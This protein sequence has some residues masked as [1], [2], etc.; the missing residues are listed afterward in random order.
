MES[1]ELISVIMPCFNDAQCVEESVQSVLHQTYEAIEL[2]VVDDGSTDR[3]PEILASLCEGDKRMRLFSQPNQGGGVARNRGLKEAKGRYV[4]FLDSDDWWAEDC[5]E[6]LHS[7]L[8]KANADIAYCGWM[9]I[10]LPGGKGEPFVPPDYSQADLVEL[11]LGGCLWPVNATLTRIELINRVNGFNAK[12][13]Y[14]QD[15]ALWLEIIP[16]ATVVRV[17]E[18]L[19]YYRHYDGL[20]TRRNRAKQALGHYAVQIEFLQ[21]HPEVIERLGERRIAELTLGTVLMRGYECYWERDLDS[22]RELFRHV[23]RN[24]YGALRDWKYMVPALLPLET[25]RKLVNIFS[26]GSSVQLG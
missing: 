2:I 10:G 23:M 24:R 15:Y 16:G 18:A 5:L 14:C 13:K 26:R 8:I 19:A 7:P 17:P 4:A 3:S 20:R 12:W 1:S 25:H 11:F 9:N 6:K 22:A 21:K